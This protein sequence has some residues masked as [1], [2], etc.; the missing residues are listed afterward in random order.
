MVNSVFSSSA[1]F[2]I[3]SMKLHKGVIKQ[4]DKYRKH[5]LWRRSDLNSRKPPKASWSLVCL[6]KHEGGMG[7]ID[8][9]AHNNALLLKFLHIF[10]YRMGIPWVNLIWNTYYN[11][12]SLPGQ[13]KKGSFWWRDIVKL[14]DIY[15]KL[16][17]VKVA[18]GTTVLFW[19]DS[20]SGQAL[21]LAYSELYSFV[22]DKGSSFKKAHGFPLLIQN[23]HVPFT[24]QAH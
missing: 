4:L 22:K 13:K 3:S 17:S 20:W 23:F 5:C 10:Y 14:L 18:D 6:P 24:I 11:D 12:G 1:V 7:V 16:A 15:K 21:N 9:T 19:T 8:L 2:Y